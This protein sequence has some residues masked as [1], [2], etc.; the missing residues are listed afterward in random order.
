MGIDKIHVPKRTTATVVVVVVVAVVV[1]VVVYTVNYTSPGTGQPCI[2]TAA[3]ITDRRALSSPPPSDSLRAHAGRKGRG[4]NRDPEV[5][6]LN[7]RVDG[8][9]GGDS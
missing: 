5:N 6:G 3:L 7:G 9:R 2:I 8:G 4:G 1:V